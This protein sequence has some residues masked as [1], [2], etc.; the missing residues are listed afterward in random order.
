MWRALVIGC[1]RIA[2]GYNQSPSDV[3]VL[4]HALAYTRHTDFVLAG[5]VDPNPTALAEFA[6]RWNVP[7][8]FASTDDALN[9]QNFDIASICTPTGTQLDVLSKLLASDVPRVFAEKPLDGAPD[10]A[11]QIASR[12]RAAGRVLAVNFARRWDPEM[13]HLRDEIAAGNWGDLRSVVGWYGRG[14]VNNGSHMIDLAAFICGYAPHLRSVWSARSDGVDDDPTVDA[15]LDLNGC[16]FHLVGNDGRDYTRFELTLSFSRGV[17]EI[18]ESGLYVR[19]RRLGQSA[20]FA[21]VEVASDVPRVSTGYGKAM[22]HALDDISR[23]SPGDRLA[24]DAEIGDPSYCARC[25]N[26][27]PRSC[28]G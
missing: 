28:R 10:R 19:R 3:L 17:I 1:G 26:P 27:R 6:V 4:T 14:V 12:Y 25:R 7:A 15:T 16:P 9:A 11:R 21:N 22:L 13:R 8:T 2:G 24:S 5:C 18:L 23:A 20:H